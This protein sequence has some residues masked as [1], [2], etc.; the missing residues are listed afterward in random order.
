MLDQFLREQGGVA[1][2]G[3]DGGVLGVPGGAHHPGDGQGDGSLLQLLLVHRA[4]LQ[5]GEGAVLLPLVPVAGR[6][7][8]EAVAAQLLVGEVQGLRV[9][10]PL[11]GLQGLVVLVFRE[12]AQLPQGGGGNGVPG[13]EHQHHLM[14]LLGPGPVEQLV[15]VGDHL[16][17]RL[18]VL[19]GGHLGE[20][21]GTFAAGPQGDA[22]HPV[23][24]G[25]AVL[26]PQGFAGVHPLPLRVVGVDGEVH[27][28]PVD[29]P[30]FPQVL[31]DGAVL[32]LQVA[33][34]AGQVVLHNAGGEGLGGLQRPEIRVGAGG[35][36][37]L[38]P[39][40]LPQH[41][42]LYAD[43]A[44][45]VEG[46][47]GD[48]HRVGGHGVLLHVGD[49]PVHAGGQSQN[50]GDADDADAPGEGGEQGAALFRPQVVEAER[51][52][53]AEGHGDLPALLGRPLRL[54]LC[55]GPGV[56]HNLPVQQ[57]DDAGG[58]PVRQLRVVGDHDHQL[59]PGDLL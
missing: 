31:V 57:P 25:V 40:V 17:H 6:H 47:V 22:V 8:V 29:H 11:D 59:V 10:S 9:L 14:G 27:V 15:V 35:V 45:H 53:G 4:L 13:V 28:V 49:V 52:G 26:L 21:G 50:Q 19:A 43:E 30:V 46:L 42:P 23:H 51:Q 41:L 16:A 2:G 20:V 55:Q 24:H 34:K 32:V 1:H 37:G 38:F 5:Q 44:G 48:G 39:A 36:R 54:L 3:G 7:Q 58:V 33:F 18:P 12:K 56:V